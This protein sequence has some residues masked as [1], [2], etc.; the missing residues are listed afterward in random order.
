MLRKLL[1]QLF[2]LGGSITHPFFQA[3]VVRHRDHYKKLLSRHG[4]K[5]P[6]WWFN[7]HGIDVRDLLAGPCASIERDPE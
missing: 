7:T 3:E 4:D 2:R 6:A 1:R 5:S